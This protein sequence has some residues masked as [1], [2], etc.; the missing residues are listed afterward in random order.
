M[1]RSEFNFTRFYLE[2][3]KYNVF[4]CEMQ[5]TDVQ[6]NTEGH[7]DSGGREEYRPFKSGLRAKS[8]S[9]LRYEAEA[10]GI[11]KK[12]GGLE[13]IRAELGFSRRSMCQLLLV[14]PSAWT[15]WT[16]DTTS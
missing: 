8:S 4:N 5:N 2:K 9:R 16:R 13:G 6:N 1:P 15:R 7:L 11:L 10:Q 14:D 3:V 12:L